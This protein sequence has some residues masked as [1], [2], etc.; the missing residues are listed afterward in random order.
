MPYS[1]RQRYTLSDSMVLGAG[2]ANREPLNPSTCE[3]AT[4]D[5]MIIGSGTAI[6]R[7][8]RGSP[9]IAVVIKER[10]ILFDIGPG[11]LR[12]LTRAGINYEQIEYVF[13]THFHPD[14]T[15]DLIHFIF[16][17][18]NPTVL[19]RRRPFKVVGPPGTGPLIE[20]LQAAYPG[21]LTL[22]PEMMEIQ[23][24]GLE[25]SLQSDFG[26][27]SLVTTPTDHTPHSLAYRVKDC[28]GKT[29]V[30]AG[31]TGYCQDV[32]DLAKGVDLLILE[33]SFPDGK[34]CEGHLTPSLAGEMAARAGVRRLV[35]IHFYPECLATDVAAQ[36]RRTYGGELILGEDLLRLRVQGGCQISD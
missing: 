18:R 35:L 32:V 3:P 24:L 31:D 27:F 2:S 36:C 10:L 23:E 6:P 28:E 19:K 20:A 15:A 4:M 12:Q 8:D 26:D 30:Y 34:G 29:L 17:S 22:P 11:T 7:S 21:W 25:K 33:S 13:L 5:V 9:A 14:H 1:V 16:A